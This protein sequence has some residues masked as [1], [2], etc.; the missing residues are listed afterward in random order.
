[1]EGNERDLGV[2]RERTGHQRAFE[3]R[4]GSEQRE[5]TDRGEHI[6]DHVR[7][8][9]AARRERAAQRGDDGAAGGAQVEAESARRPPAE[10]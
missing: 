3:R 9:G 7:E 4:Q 10:T 6:E 1:V 5:R 2:A 8:A